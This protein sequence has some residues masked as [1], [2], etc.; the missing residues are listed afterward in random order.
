MDTKH[1]RKGTMRRGTLCSLAALGIAVSLT[2]CSTEDSGNP[3]QLTNP[4]KQ[5]VGPGG[6]A[7]GGSGG[8][9]EYLDNRT[10]D[11]AA[12]YRIAANKLANRF[13]TM[14]E[15]KALDAAGDKKSKYE[16][17]IDAL[18]ADNK[19]LGEV[20]VKYF[21]DTFKT[22]SVNAQGVPLPPQMNNNTVGPNL[23]AAAY[24]AASLVVSDRPYTD[25]FTATSGT[26]PTWDMTTGAF[27][28]ANC[29]GTQPTVGVLTDPGLMAQYFSNMAFR[30]VRFIQETFI[31]SKFPATVSPKAVPMGA[32]AYTG[33]WDLKSITGKLTVPTA[34]IDFHDA[35]SVVCANCHTDMNHVAPLFVEFNQRGEFTAGQSQVSV[36]IPGNPK[37]ARAD[38]MPDGEGTA[39]R[40]GKPTADLA[41]LGAALAADPDA[42]RCAVTRFWNYGMA[43]GNVVDD[44]SP[45]AVTVS[46]PLLESFKKDFKI[47]PLLKAV[48]TADDFVKF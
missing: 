3:D 44:I 38:Y 32:G 37:A 5:A 48:F 33:T 29:T 47:K 34:K 8:A 22:G 35:A 19:V 30:R 14:E 12:A 10:P 31:C 26:C 41:A 1:E 36:P 25:L 6:T 42:A 4:D 11:Y 13:P 7:P 28:A 46:D 39:W 45:V 23:E 17:M 15:V 9:N 40:V 27:T 18:L 2:A 20:M 43:R 24:F 16:S 21:R